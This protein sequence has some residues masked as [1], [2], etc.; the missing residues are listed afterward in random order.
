LTVTVSENIG[1]DPRLSV[2]ISLTRHGHSGY[3]PINLIG[4]FISS[5]GYTNKNLL[6]YSQAMIRSIYFPAQE[7]PPLHNLL[8]VDITNALKNPEGLLWINLERPSE[9][10]VR[11]I[12]AG[13][14]N[15]HPL[16]IEDCLSTGYQTPKIDDFGSYVFLITHA[17][18]SNGDHTLETTLELDLFLGCFTL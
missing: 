4:L 10:E 8:A 2:I 5:A 6:L 9:K 14:F 3:Y 1:A 7:A 11:E 15:F 12:L 16:A 18:P 17:I 13:L